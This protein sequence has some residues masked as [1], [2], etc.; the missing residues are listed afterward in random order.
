M[1][2]RWLLAIGLCALTSSVQGESLVSPI[3]SSTWV[4]PDGFVQESHQTDDEHETPSMREA[5]ARPITWRDAGPTGEGSAGL[6][7]V[8]ILAINDFH[9]QLSA[10]SRV[11]SRPV[12]GAAGLAAYLKAAQRDAA[13]GSGQERTFLV[14]AGDHVGASPPESSLFQDEPSIT[15]FNLLGNRH[16]SYV[17]RMNPH[18]NLVGTPGN[19]E[20]DEGRAELLRLIAGGTHR[21]GPFIEDPYRGARF[22]YV[23]ANVVDKGTGQPILPPYVIKEVAGVRLAFIGAVLQETPSVVPPAGVAGL[24]FLDEATS[25]NRYVKRLRATEGIRAFIV[26][27]HQGG[28]QTAYEGPTQHHEVALGQSIEDIVFQLDDEV[29]LVVSGHT[30]AFT[31]ALVK[32]RQGREILV[33]QA[34]SSGTAYGHIDMTLDRETGEVVAKRAAIVTTY[35]DAGP[36]LTPDREVAQLVATVEAKVAPLV[37]RVIGHA[38]ADIRRVQNLAG[39]SALGNLIADAQRIALGTD[40]ALMNPGGIRTDVLAGPVTYRDL[41]TVQPFGNSLVRMTLTGQQIY[42]LLNQQWVSQPPR[43]LQ[44]SGLTYMWDQD[45]PV[46]DRIVDIRTRGVPLD[47]AARYSVTVNDFLAAGGDHFA[48]LTHGQDRAGGPLDLTALVTY[49]HTLPQP[50]SAQVE[51]RITRVH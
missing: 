34:F 28:R 38:A 20:F 49:L 30:H 19:H 16:C 14:H 47:R 41:F 31:N 15:F 36:G 45:R 33:T 37:A 11:G 1:P 2:A 8:T 42:D 48:V 51:L 40:F 27:I 23:S 25:I 43:M 12:G 13:D 9:G 6:E 24:R 21:S 29:D 7:R 17:D 5:A 50:F 26:L 46:D 3:A 35:A 32:N 10:G 22:P 4:Q 18:C 44:V 39:E